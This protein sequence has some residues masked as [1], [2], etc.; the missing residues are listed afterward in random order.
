MA[1]VDAAKADAAYAPQR[2]TTFARCQAAEAGTDDHHP[3]ASA[4]RHA[5]G[6]L[7]WQAT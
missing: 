6:I 7:S 1:K 2:A 3:F 4:R 5:G